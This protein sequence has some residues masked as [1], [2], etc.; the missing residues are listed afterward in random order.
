MKLFLWKDYSGTVGFTKA[1]AMKSWVGLWWFDNMKSCCL[2]EFLTEAWP[3]ESRVFC[4]MTWCILSVV[5]AAECRL[6]SYGENCWGSCNCFSQNTQRCD[7]KTGKCICKPGYRGSRCIQGK[8]FFPRSFSTPLR[9][10][11][12]FLVHSLEIYFMLLLYLLF[13]NVLSFFLVHFIIYCFSPSF[14]FAL[15]WLLW[16]TLMNYL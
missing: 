11:H 1:W 7:F 4:G 2:P 5:C 14:Y 13:N 6:G 15:L 8:T 3:L 9:F 16:N 12:S 10:Y